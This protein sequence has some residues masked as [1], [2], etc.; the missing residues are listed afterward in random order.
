M[1]LEHK[2]ILLGITGSI[3]AYKVPELIRLLQKEGATIQV[4]VTQ[5]ATHF[6]TPLTLEALSGFPV[7]Q[8]FLAQNFHDGDSSMVHL[9]PSRHADVVLIVPATA[10]IL[11]KFAYGF[12][13]D[14]VSATVLGSRTPV[15]IVPAMNTQMWENPLVQENVHKLRSVYKVMDPE[16]G[17][18][19]CGEYGQ[20]RLP[21]LDA[22][23]QEIIRTLTKQD[24]KGKKILLTA[25]AT[26]EY[27][28]PV[29]FISNASTGKMAL[30]L[31]QEAYAR[32][33]QVTIV[34]GFTEVSFR[35][36]MTIGVKIFEVTSAT[37]MVEQTLK[38]IAQSDIFL[39]PAAIADYF[40][41]KSYSMKMKKRKQK[42]SL[43]L[44]PTTDLL[45]KISTLKKRPFTVG[46]A[47]ED[48][49]NEQ[50]AF[51]KL[52]KKKLDLLVLNDC[53]SLGNDQTQVILCHG[54][55]ALPYLRSPKESLSR[56]IFDYIVKC[57]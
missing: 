2:H 20:G 25:G 30:A 17:T 11:A 56:S 54:S 5:A 50:I 48:T 6:V 32:G 10:D 28:D 29:R 34:K 4:M 51:Q 19:A 45:E 13:D 9:Q 26:R 39:C 49:L 52:A 40:P 35:H 27:I 16:E 36:L 18:L 41:A 12:A 31:A 8:N 22:I 1:R 47:L 21:Q 57:F 14:L 46:F 53:T 38:H 42:I 43:E 55:K 37:E 24:L 44:L 7:L 23:M 3:A 33:A 15:L